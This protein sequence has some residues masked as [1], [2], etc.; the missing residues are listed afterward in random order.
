MPG[1][2]EISL[3]YY[4][5]IGPTFI[6]GGVTLRFDSLQPYGF[7]STAQWPTT[8]NYESTVQKAVEKVLKERQGHLETTQVVLTAIEWD[9]INSCADGFRRAA[10]A[11]TR[12]AFED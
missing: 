6:H 3:R 1:Q 9:K 2:V 12:A 11:A 10:T 8:D 5:H 7:A 4:R